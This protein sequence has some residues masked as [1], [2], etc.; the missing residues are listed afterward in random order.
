MAKPRLPQS[1][2][3]A[4]GAILKNAGRFAGRSAPKVARPV[5]EPYARMTDEQKACWYEFAQDMP[6]LNAAHRT[7]LRLACHLAARLDLDA[8]FGV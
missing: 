6:W 1:R 3:E 4:S 2:A 7:L 8:E 5:G